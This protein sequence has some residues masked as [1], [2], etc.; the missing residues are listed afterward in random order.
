MKAVGP[1]S[2]AEIVPFRFAKMKWA[3]PPVP[4]ITGKLEGLG[5]PLL[6][7]PVGPGGPLA[8]V[9]GGVPAAGGRSVRCCVAG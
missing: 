2:Q 5:F 6:T 7:C 9:G 8:V 3:E 4:P 1:V